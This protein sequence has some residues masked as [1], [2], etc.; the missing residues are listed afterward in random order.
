MADS[1]VRLEESIRKLRECGCRLTPQRRAVLKILIEDRDHPSVE[2]IYDQVKQGFPMT[3]LATVYKTVALLKEMGEVREIEFGQGRNRYDGYDPSLHPHL[4]CVE[5][6][7]IVDLDLP[8]LSELVETVA[9]QKGYQILRHRF[10]FFG[11]CPQCQA[12]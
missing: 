6:K 4:I 7:R 2:Q 12:A 8:A 11:I 9:Q 3:S 10:D 5:C 1:D